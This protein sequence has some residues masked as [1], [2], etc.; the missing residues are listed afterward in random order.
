MATTNLSPNAA[1]KG[2]KLLPVIVPS[3]TLPDIH[4]DSIIIGVCGTPV[5]EADPIDGDGWFI[6]DFCAFNYLLKGLGRKQTWISTASEEELL[7][8]VVNDS[9][10][11]PGFLHGNPFCDRKIVFNK[12]LVE[13]QELTPFTVCQ[14]HLVVPTLLSE[15]RLACILARETDP[16]ASVLVLL[17]GHGVQSLGICLDY[18]QIIPEG[19]LVGSFTIEQLQSAVPPEVPVTLLTTACYSGGWAVRPDLNMT[20]LTAAGD[21]S[22]Q[23]GTGNHL[24]TWLSLAWNDSPSVGRACGSMFATTVISAL[25]ASTSP[26]LDDD[27]PQDSAGH[28]PLQPSLATDAQTETYNEFCS[29]IVRTL[30][31]K[32]TRRPEFHDFRFAAQDDEWDQCWMGRTGV[33]LSYF[34]QRWDD[35]PVYKTTSPNSFLNLDPNNP[36]W[37]SDQT[38]ESCIPSSRTGSFV[39][40]ALRQ[41]GRSQRVLRR[42]MQATAAMLANS[43]PGDWQ[44][45]PNHR[46][47]GLLRDY[48]RGKD[49]GLQ[50][51][52]FLVNV[53]VFRLQTADFIDTI[54]TNFGLTRPFGQKCLS[55]DRNRW[56]DERPKTS[57]KYTAICNCIQ[58][59]GTTFRGHEFQGNGFSRAYL[60]LAAALF[61]SGLSK[62]ATF[63]VIRQV[64]ECINGEAEIA[65][66]GVTKHSYVRDRAA[67]WFGSIG[68]T[69]RSISPSKRSRSGTRTSSV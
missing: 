60:Y 57:E 40:Q 23:P 27:Y 42:S 56:Y 54:V 67:R 37:Q 20:V 41:D 5:G 22:A 48:A 68:K 58:E 25:T 63:H 13:R 31:E 24:Q 53:M 17:F 7:N 59:V 29:S 30:G 3:H 11:Y 49:R 6:S 65:K 39:P 26:L 8:F 47:R 52:E 45:G 15:I 35:A 2:R 55:W 4:T 33:P 16:P 64:D 19:D 18:S 62:E 46:I 66:Q 36:I 9:R 10:L 28:N 12:E 34:R 21:I 51:E 44:A 43:C 69:L 1:Y 38:G 50:R 14:S 61:D 32:V